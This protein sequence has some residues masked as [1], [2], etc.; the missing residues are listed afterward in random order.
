MMLH[1][2]YPNPFNP[3]T[4]LR[5]DLPVA[6]DVALAIYDVKGREVNRLVNTLQQ[7]GSYRVSWN[8]RGK[9]GAPMASGI[10][11][12]RITGPDYSHSI[13]MVLLK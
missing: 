12:A 5:Y 1:A 10:Y 9:S 11:F 8:G 2:N 3:S 6:G 7:P 13:K 4:I